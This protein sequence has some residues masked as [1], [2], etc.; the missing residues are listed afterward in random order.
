M[1]YTVFCVLCISISSH[2]CRAQELKPPIDIDTVAET[3]L[4]KVPE[5]DSGT[6]ER[7]FSPSPKPMGERQAPKL[8]LLTSA[9]VYSAALLD[10][11]N[12][13][14]AMNLCSS[15][16]SQY[17]CHENNPFAR[18]F[19]GLPAPAYYATGL[20][21]ATGITWL[22]WRMTRSE[23]FRH[24]WFLP[25]IAAMAANGLGYASSTKVKATY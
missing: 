8:F 1:R 18:P 20:A 19:V 7:P 2:V 24:T 23:K 16:P 10:M 12:T 17:V 15:Q 6:L 4:M 22:S 13:R 3:K 9:G 21:L 25:Q 5:L 11:R 14:N